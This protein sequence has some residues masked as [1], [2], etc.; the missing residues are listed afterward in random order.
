MTLGR[1]PPRLPRVFRAHLPP[2]C[3]PRRRR[4]RRRGAS[5]PHADVSYPVPHMA[6]DTWTEVMCHTSA[7]R[8]RTS[9]LA[10]TP[11]ACPASPAGGQGVTG[12]HSARR[13]CHGL[14]RPAVRAVPPPASPAPSLRL[15]RREGAAAPRPE[16]CVGGRGRATTGVSCR[17][18]AGSA[19]CAGAAA[20]PSEGRR[21]TR[22]ARGRGPPPVRCAA[23]G[24]RVRPR[25]GGCSGSA[26]RRSR[27]RAARRRVL[28]AVGGWVRFQ[29]KSGRKSS[30]PLPSI[31]SHVGLGVL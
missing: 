9:G 1:R 16:E 22:R 21:G 7:A 28:G 24:V 19:R 10:R 11:P 13:G 20:L 25:G 8:P 3:R 17:R 6:H 31:S 30:S 26:R 23:V 27:R 12:A 2:P 14:P 5:R 18:R 29:S 4:C 15:C